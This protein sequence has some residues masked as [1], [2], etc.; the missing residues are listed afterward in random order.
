[1]SNHIRNLVHALKN[2]GR[3]V[4]FILALITFFALVVGPFF[5]TMSYVSAVWPNVITGIW[6][7][8]FFVFVIALLHEYE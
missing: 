4:I 2:T 7:I 8:V 5:L 1:M 6:G 3:A